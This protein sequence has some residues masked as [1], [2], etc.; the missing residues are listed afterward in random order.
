MSMRS[1]K[2]YS[3][4]LEGLTAHL[5]FKPVWGTKLVDAREREREMQ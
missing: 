3:L 2:R 1:D 4:D 5:I